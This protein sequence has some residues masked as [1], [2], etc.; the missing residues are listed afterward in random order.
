MEASFA[1]LFPFL[2]TASES[3]PGVAKGKCGL[4]LVCL[5][6]EA[7]VDRTGSPQRSRH[8]GVARCTV[9]IFKF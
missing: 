8:N 1:E 2:R 3:A 5:P 6:L 9:A 7:T 4:D